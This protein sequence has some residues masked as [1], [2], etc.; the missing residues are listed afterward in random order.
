MSL[1]NGLPAFYLCLIAKMMGGP[2]PHLTPKR[3]ESSKK[4]MAEWVVRR[5][6]R[7]WTNRMKYD[8][9]LKVSFTNLPRLMLLSRLLRTCPIGSLSG[10]MPNE[11][12]VVVPKSIKS[13]R[14]L[15]RRYYET[16]LTFA[17]EIST[18]THFVVVLI[19]RPNQ[20]DSGMNLTIEVFNRF[21]G[22]IYR[23]NSD[24]KLM[25]CEHTTTLCC[26]NMEEECCKKEYSR[27]FY[28]MRVDIPVSNLNGCEDSKQMFAAQVVFYTS[29]APIYISTSSSKRRKCIA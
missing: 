12:I 9:E 17:V 4:A 14:D 23:T 8:A 24:V 7:I 11:H 26:V 19:F 25:E 2:S 29:T 27:F 28:T 15:F 18:T 5:N 21:Q 6:R 10:M 16:G 20:N 1:P 13:L 3:L 22:L